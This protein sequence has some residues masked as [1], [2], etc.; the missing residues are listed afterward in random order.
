[1]QRQ[2]VGE[3]LQALPLGQD[4]KN[5]LSYLTVEAGLSENTVLAYGRDLKSFLE[6]CKSNNIKRT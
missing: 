3:K 4:V 1:M 6:H 2:S 5:F